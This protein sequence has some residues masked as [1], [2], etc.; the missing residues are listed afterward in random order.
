MAIDASAIIGL[1]IGFLVVGVI[2]IYVGDQMISAAGIT[3]TAATV[4]APISALGAGAWTVPTDVNSVDV[5]LVGSGGGG[6]SGSNLTFKGG[7][8]GAAGAVTTQT[9]LAV[10]PGTLL[11]Y[12]IG[13]VGDGR[14]PV[15]SSDITGINGTAGGWASI[16]IGGITYNATGGTWGMNGTTLVGASATQNGGAGNNGYGLTPWAP[17]GGVGTNITKPDPSL[18]AGING[19][20]SRGYGA[21]GP[22]GGAG[23]A[24]AGAPGQ[25]GDATGADGNLGA[26]LITYY[27]TNAGLNALGPTQ[28]SIVD[29]FAL[30]VN[31]CK[32]IVIVSIASI[33]FMLLQKTG[34]IPRF[35]QE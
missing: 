26:V 2:G 18:I 33:I 19:T 24:G 35:G 10:T 31:L 12:Y 11:L 4:A 22:G 25:S 7:G 28:Q 14:L 32:I 34:L 9:G 5:I 30:G 3:G 21:G 27:T 15:T 13:P 1:L 17:A 8:G 6:G 16:I 20:P 23:D 29:T